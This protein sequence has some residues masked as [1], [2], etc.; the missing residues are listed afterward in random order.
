MGTHFLDP[1]QYKALVRRQ[2]QEA[3]GAW[4]QWMPL[5]RTWLGPA[6]GL[7]LDLAQVQAGSRVLEVGAGEG[8]LSRSAA[9]RTGPQ[10]LVLATDLAPAMLAIADRAA[11]QVGLSHLQT[12]EMDGEHLE[13]ES[14]TFDAVLCRL[15]LVCFQDAGKGL[16]E[17][18]RVLKPG[19]R[20]AVMVFSSPERNPFLSAPLSALHRAA[21]E[22]G[23]NPALPSPFQLSARGVL[24]HALD[25]AGFRDV[26][27]FIL[28]APL[29]LALAQECVRMEREAFAMLHGILEGVEPARQE[30]AW[31][32]VEQALRAFE[33]PD[34][35]TSPGEVIVAVGVKNGE[36]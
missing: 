31:L 20:A 29:H 30:Q 24:A 21:A 15:G 34:G 4:N 35:F 33:G 18:M 2:W 5:I 11:Q 26:C 27:T 25:W 13:L 7:M 17:M 9:R 23:V 3:A 14:S 1:L 28:S 16:A 8:D 36:G 19:G 12:Q 32:E 22:A 6:S 10:G